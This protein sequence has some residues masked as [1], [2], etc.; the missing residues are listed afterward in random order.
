L[1]LQ[2]LSNP[3]KRRLFAGGLLAIGQGRVD[4]PVSAA[5]VQEA[6]EYYR[7]LVRE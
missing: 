2:P 5:Q 7:L 4:V 1:N 3:L 6:V